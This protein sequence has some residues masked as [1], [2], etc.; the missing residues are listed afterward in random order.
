[1]ELEWVG[2]SV[3]L[4]CPVCAHTEDQDLLARVDV[5]WRDEPVDI[6]RCSECGAVVLGAMLPP[7]MYTDADWDWYVEQIA[8]IEAIAD[9]LGQ[10]GMRRGVRM[11]DVGCGY[12]FALDLGRFL[13]EWEGVGL[14]PSI[15]AARGRRD[16]D[17]DI[18]P[19]TLDDAFEPDERFDVIFSSE[20]IEHIADPRDFL[21]AVRR[22]LAPNGI[23]VLTTPDATA[24]T[25][26]TPWTTLYPVL[27]VGLHEFLVDAPGL[28]RMLRDAGFHA[29]VWHVGFSLRAVASIASK[30]LAAVRQETRVA[31]GDL[32]SYCEMRCA[33]AEPGSALALGMATRQLKW[34]VSAHDFERAS[35]HLPELRRALF[36]R[37]AIDLDDPKVLVG[38]AALPAVLTVIFYNLGLIQ[39]WHEHSPRRAADS[40]EAAAWAGRAQWD[41]YGQYQDPETPAFEALARGHF[42][43]ALARIAPEHVAAVLEDLDE[44]VTRGAG[45]VEMAATARARAEAELT[46]R[47]SPTRRAYR[48]LRSAAGRVRRRLR[49]RV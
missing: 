28:E 45:D 29:R 16:L 47:R 34:M 43:L 49:R 39:L 18:R 25:P 15:A 11:L 20:V 30:E 37:Y 48:R 24:V 42:A 22:R 21:A 33:A 19:G 7:S 2:G 31:L 10:T 12:G 6:A 41:L 9:T 44:G 8:G 38:R 26:E 27:S 36:D 13:F 14:D 4:R 32:A 35:A 40:F 5:P 23:L 3:D 46:S 17:L 1:M